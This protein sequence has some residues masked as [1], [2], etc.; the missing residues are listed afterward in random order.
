MADNPLEIPQA[1]RH[2]D[3]ATFQRDRRSYPEV[4]TRRPW[5]RDGRDALNSHG[6]WLQGCTRS[7]RG[8]R[9]EE[10]RVR[11]RAGRKDRQG[12][13]F[14]GDCDTSDPFCS[15]ADAGLRRA[16]AG[17]SR[18]DRGNSPE[19]PTRLILQQK[20]R[21]LGGSAA[22]W[23]NAK[24]HNK[25]DPHL[26]PPKTPESRLNSSLN[27]QHAEVWARSAPHYLGCL[28]RN[29]RKFLC[30]RRRQV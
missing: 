26:F 11:L 6:R 10:C 29:L 19:A 24:N 2:A 27:C 16:D 18:A 30:L 12:T 7:C 8:N 13:E 5:R 22:S 3:A 4:G 17:A 15:R 21:P 14:T 25:R 20:P 23:L 28:L 9:E 1:L